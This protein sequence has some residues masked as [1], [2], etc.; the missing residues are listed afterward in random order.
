MRS[1][2]LIVILAFSLA[3]WQDGYYE[4]DGSLYLWD[5]DRDWSYNYMISLDPSLISEQYGDLELY[6]PDPF[7]EYTDLSEYPEDY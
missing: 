6:M 3:E 7:Y 1:V 2:I 4:V 5:N